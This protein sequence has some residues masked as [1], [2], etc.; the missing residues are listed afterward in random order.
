M[1]EHLSTNF[2]NKSTVDIYNQGAFLSIFLGY[3]MDLS[4]H[5]NV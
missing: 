2:L 4:V 3:P 5:T 1:F